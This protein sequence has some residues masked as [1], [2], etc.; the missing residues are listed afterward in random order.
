MKTFALTVV[1]FEGLVGMGLVALVFLS[2]CSST[3]ANGILEGGPETGKFVSAITVEN[4]SGQTVVT[5]PYESL[6]TWLEQNKNVRIVSVACIDRSSG[7]RTSAVL[8][9]YDK[10]CLNKCPDCGQPLPAEKTN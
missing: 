3:D 2:G 4:S 6:K 5:I 9:V 1:L 8:I 7:G 10:H